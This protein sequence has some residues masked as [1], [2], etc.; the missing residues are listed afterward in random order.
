MTTIDVSGFD[1]ALP[2]VFVSSADAG[3][4]ACAV[5][6]DLSPGPVSR[7][8]ESTLP[9]LYALPPMTVL[10]ERSAQGESLER[11]VN[12]SQFVLQFASAGG[13]DMLASQAVMDRIEGGPWLSPARVRR[14][15]FYEAGN[16]YLTSFFVV[17]RTSDGEVPASHRVLLRDADSFAAFDADV[18]FER[19]VRTGVFGQRVRRTPESIAERLDVEA[20]RAL[21]LYN[22]IVQDF[23]GKFAARSPAGRQLDR[24]VRAG[25]LDVDG[26]S[27]I[28][29]AGMAYVP[30]MAFVNGTEP[31][32]SAKTTLRLVDPDVRPDDPIGWYYLA[33]MIFPEAD[34]AVQAYASSRTI[35]T[36]TITVG[37]EEGTQTRYQRA[38]A[39][40]LVIRYALLSLS[41]ADQSDDGRQAYEAMC[42]LFVRLTDLLFSHRAWY[43]VVELATGIKQ[44]EW[45]RDLPAASEE[46][47]MA[48]GEM[49]LLFCAVMYAVRKEWLAQGLRNAQALARALGK[50]PS[51]RVALRIQEYALFDEAAARRDILSA[52]EG[53]GGLPQSA[54]HGRLNREG[55]WPS[56]VAW[57]SRAPIKC[58]IPGVSE[59]GEDPGDFVPVP[60]ELVVAPSG[61]RRRREETETAIVPVAQ[62]QAA[63]VVDVPA[64]AVDQAQ[65]DEAVA[66]ASQ[67]VR[68]ELGEACARSIAERE[69]RIAQLEA[70]I[71]DLQAQVVA[72]GRIRDQSADVSR[73]QTDLQAKTDEVAALRS[74]LAALQSALGDARAQEAESQKTYAAL[75]NSYK[76]EIARIQ[77]ELNAELERCRQDLEKCSQSAKQFE[78]DVTRC[79]RQAGEQV[80][81]VIRGVQT[82]EN[83]CRQ[84][85]RAAVARATRLQNRIDQ[86]ERGGCG[87]PGQRGQLAA[88]QEQI[89][90]LRERIEKQTADLDALRS[91]NADLQQQLADRPTPVDTVMVPEEETE[92]DRAL[93]E[94]LTSQL[95]RLSV[96]RDAALSAYQQAAAAAQSLA[97]QNADL[98]SRVQTAA[99]QLAE[100]NAELEDSIAVR[101]SSAGA[102]DRLVAERD[103]LETRVRDLEAR[104]QAPSAPTC[105]IEIAVVASELEQ[106]HAEAF[107]QLRAEYQSA[108]AIVQS[109]LEACQTRE[110]ELRAEAERAFASLQLLAGENAQL[111]AVA[112]A[113]LETRLEALRSFVDGKEFEQTA[114]SISKCEAELGELR[115]QRDALRRSVDA[116]QAMASRLDQENAALRSRTDARPGAQPA[117][118]FEGQQ[119][120]VLVLRAALLSQIRA[121][122]KSRVMALQLAVRDLM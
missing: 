92:Q 96:D 17:L 120:V 23:R 68:N 98:E 30:M 26:R 41:P 89:R 4:D 18:V 29:P 66:V 114:A 53:R 35:S 57:A 25:A 48:E 69:T 78:S 76:Q 84:Q 52:L 32:S 49:F 117:G 5:R 107:Q 6:L 37:V 42:S 118:S 113:S 50:G 36:T 108:L 20:V 111:A 43:A 22:A 74:D 70:Q 97:Q 110:Q 73:C 60:Q 62:P 11:G 112:D 12:L 9:D 59:I 28:S 16:V 51:G 7:F 54:F 121:N 24:E 79:A 61:R 14:I 75:E 104:P 64:P 67:K 95:Q 27:L 72:C 10:R 91:Q 34:A 77:L 85:L 40:W 44:S 58:N 45:A 21:G 87:I 100:R 115:T 31:F 65:I 105:G 38:F 46:A 86:L 39:A 80:S 94:Q 1:R 3:A 122:P 15:V 19:S 63:M 55:D 116:A 119:D 102:I 13:K 88:L 99:A 90:V 2:P 106:K 81:G 56:L 101:D 47:K 82:R 93:V 33:A 8:S 71:A 109:Q 83:V 103:E